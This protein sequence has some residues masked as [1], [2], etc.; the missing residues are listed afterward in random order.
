MTNESTQLRQIIAGLI[1]DVN[2]WRSLLAL[3]LKQSGGTITVPKEIDVD[4]VFEIV[5]R[6]NSSDKGLESLEIR[7]L[8]GKDEIE[9]VLGKPSPIIVPK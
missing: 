3:T 2:Q 1:Q 6:Y 4:G 8:Q 7:L 9:S 5:T